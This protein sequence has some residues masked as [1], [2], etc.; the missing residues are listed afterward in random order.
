MIKVYSAFII[1]YD[2]PIC[3]FMK[4]WSISTTEKIK[5]ARNLTFVYKV[6]YEEKDL[7]RPWSFMKELNAN[8][9]KL[10]VSHVVPRFLGVYT[11]I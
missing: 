3:I 5:N 8:K 2:L 9:I 6:Y 10:F 7:Q 1:R 4:I 11:V